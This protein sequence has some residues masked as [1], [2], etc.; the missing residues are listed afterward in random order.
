LKKCNSTGIAAA[1]M[2]PRRR[3]LRKVM[4]NFRRA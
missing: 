1:A 2:P 4:A 3:K